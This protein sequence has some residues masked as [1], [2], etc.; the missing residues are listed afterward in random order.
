MMNIKKIMSKLPFMRRKM[1]R[2]KFTTLLTHIFDTSDDE[3]ACDECY[4]FMEEYAEFLMHAK[5]NQE[6]GYCEVVRHLEKC[7]DCGEVFETFLKAIKS[8]G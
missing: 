6:N 4:E 2:M 8:V 7:M 3:I 1:E 5:K